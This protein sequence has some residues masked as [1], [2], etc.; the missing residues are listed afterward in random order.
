MECDVAIV[1][2]VAQFLLT[3]AAVYDTV[4]T[5]IQPFVDFRRNLIS[6]IDIQNDLYTIAARVF[7]RFR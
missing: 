3:H 5:I 4:H 6:G 7:Q 1:V 2:D